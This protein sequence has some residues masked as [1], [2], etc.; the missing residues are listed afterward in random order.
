MAETAGLVQEMLDG[1]GSLSEK[2]FQESTQ[3]IEECT[4][5]R[6]GQAPAM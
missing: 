6:K 3:E 5:G 2:C 1:R 4:A